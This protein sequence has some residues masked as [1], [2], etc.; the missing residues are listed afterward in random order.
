MVRGHC[1]VSHDPD[2]DRGLTREVRRKIRV[3]SR[4]YTVIEHRLFKRGMDGILRILRGTHF[5]NE[6]FQELT[7]R[8]KI[9][10]SKTT[11]Y[12]PHTNGQTERVN[13]TLV[14]ILRKT[15]LDSKRDWDVKLTTTL[16]AYHMTFKVTTQATPFSLVY[17]LEATLPIEFEVE[18]L[19]VA[20]KSRLTD[21][22]SLRNRLTTLEELDERR[23]MSV[24][25]IE[26]IQRRRKITFDKQH[27]KRALMPGMMV[28]IQDARMLDFP[29]KFDAI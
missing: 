4:H 24:Q 18:S 5:L 7:T 10:H 3:N 8:F 1:G 15:V 20:V 27:K 22:Q 6:M 9:D 26:A 21:N 28:M 25:H 13:G 29:G 19:R 14:S 16:W 17:G 11:P 23:K 2:F 12:H